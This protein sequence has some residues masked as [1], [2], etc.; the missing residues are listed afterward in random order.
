MKEEDQSIAIAVLQTQYET[1]E[2]K[3]DNG[4]DRLEIALDNSK[5]SYNGKLKMV[6]DRITKEENERERCYNGHEERLRSVETKQ[7]VVITKL[8]MIIS[9]VIFAI[10]FAFDK[11]WD[12]VKDVF[13]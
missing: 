7:A 6:D 2:K 9:G 3:I 13:K 11:I 4:F 1:I 8:A 5:V 12:F 10:T